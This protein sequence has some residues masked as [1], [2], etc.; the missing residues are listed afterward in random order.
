MRNKLIIAI[1]GTL[2][3][4]ACNQKEMK[5]SRAA[6]SVQTEMTD[7]SPAYISK[8]NEGIAELNKNNLIGNTH[9]IL[10]VDRDLELNQIAPFLKEL[11]DKKYQKDGMH[12]DSKA[13]YFV[14]SDTLN[15]QNAYVKLP[16]KQFNLEKPS[17]NDHT[18][19]DKKMNVEKFVNRLIEMEKQ[20]PS[21]PVKEEVFIY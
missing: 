14:Y 1:F 5:I 17:E 13:I 3:L 8:N 11:T 9:W 10:S 21:N 4:N 19:F 18:F 20:K 2:L 16:F 7:F 6:Y 15:K 12:P